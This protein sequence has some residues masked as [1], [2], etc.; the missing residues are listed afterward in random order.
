MGNPFD[1]DFLA[2]YRLIEESKK[3]VSNYSNA[4]LIDL[5]WNI[6]RY[7]SDKATKEEWGKGVV[8]QLADF[9]R[10]RTPGIAGFSSQNL[11]RMKQFYETY[12][13]DEKLSAVLREIAWSK[14]LHIMSKTKT[15][16][17]RT[18][19]LALA[20]KEKYSVRELERQ[21]NSGL[22]ERAMLS[23]K[24]L[25]TVLRELRPEVE[26]TLRD[27]YVLEFLDLPERYE[28]KDLRKAIVSNLRSF[29][30]EIGRDFTFVGEEYR[31]QVGNHDYFLDL[32]F[33]HRGL[34]C[35]VAFELK[36]DEFKPEYLGKMNF[37][38][39]ALDRDVK[40]EHE[41]P[42]V[43]VLL[44][45]NKDRDVVEYAMSRTLSPTMIAEYRTKLIG[46]QV[47]ERKLH[48]LLL[49]SEKK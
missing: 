10:E 29:I 17:E 22:F 42:S 27:S 44:C 12:Q 26:G 49:L 6:G 43:G 48:E 3:R 8:N 23:D 13:E 30:L 31:V 4:V 41:N 45:A 16:E 32:L 15:V 34:R 47:L 14:H 5:Y 19:Y 20:A 33:F 28:E 2:V 40:K 1:H 38:L 24:K 18:F 36:I 21:I 25:S 35:L 39:E 11:W 46:K 9:L 37:Y 7:I